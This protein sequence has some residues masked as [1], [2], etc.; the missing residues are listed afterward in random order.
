MSAKKGCPFDNA[1]RKH[2]YTL[3]II[4]Y[5]PE[6]ELDD[7]E[8]SYIDKFNTSFPN[9][10]NFETGGHE[11]KHHSP[12]TIQKLSQLN[13]GENNPMYGKR[14]SDEHR[15]HISERMQG[16]R[17]PR[18]GVHHTEEAK[19]K[20][21]ES[22]LGVP[23][24]EE[25][26][27]KISKSFKGNTYRK[28]IP[29]TEECKAKMSAS[30]VGKCTGGGNPMS[31]SIVQYSLDDKFIAKYDSIVDAA[32]KYGITATAISNCCRGKTVT[33]AGFKWKYL[34]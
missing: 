3:E 29:H 30:H 14:L 1:L 18:Y 4:D 7:A 31:R 20:I 23:L 6:S 13:M 26:R 8:R 34:E 12:A 5:L 16:E 15:H 22:R 33:S 21:R 19:Q 28:G 27:R 24:S 11:Y 25:T 2:S 10:W 32:R 17:N 9:G